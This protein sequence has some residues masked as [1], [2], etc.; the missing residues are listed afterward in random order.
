[1]KKNLNVLITE[2]KTDI[3]NLKEHIQAGHIEKGNDNLE[4]I[5]TARMQNVEIQMA[6]LL[7]QFEMLKD[8][9]LESS[10]LSL[11]RIE[12]ELERK[13]VAMKEYLIESFN[14]KS[15]LIDQSKNKEL[16]DI[17]E[18]QSQKLDAMS[19]HFVEK[20]NIQTQ[21]AVKLDCIER[22]LEKGT[23]DEKLITAVLAKNLENNDKGAMVNFENIIK[24]NLELNKTLAKKFVEHKLA[25]DKAFE[26]LIDAVRFQNA[27]MLS[28]LKRIESSLAIHAEKVD[29]NTDHVNQMLE[30]IINSLTINSA[31]NAREIENLKES[32]HGVVNN[33][34]K[35]DAISHSEINS[36]EYGDLDQ[37]LKELRGDLES[38]TTLVDIDNIEEESAVPTGIVSLG[39]NLK[40]LEDLI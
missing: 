8:Q 30:K 26:T 23:T 17:V 2:L 31:E 14:L 34:D 3:D 27:E 28:H 20:E 4:G 5:V 33:F 29:G 13:I 39:D 35:K 15:T 37:T 7:A 16:L 11:N 18:K 22:K 32:I 25:V 40:D 19:A 38:L 21:M 9:T 36:E 6:D 10:S 12:V 24:E 1:M